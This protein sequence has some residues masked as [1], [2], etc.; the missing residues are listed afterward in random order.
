MP[1][2]GQVETR[3]RGT[4][5]SAARAR[6]GT[7]LR[8]IGPGSI[9]NPRPPMEILDEEGLK[10][11][12]DAAFQIL[13]EI[14]ID[15]M[16]E[17]AQSL[18]T[19][20]GSVRDANTGRMLIGRE[21]VTELA[22]KAP[23]QFTLHARNPDRNIILGGN[24]I[25]FSPVASAPFATD[26]D[27][28]RRTGRYED[29]CGLLKLAQTYNV[30]HCLAG[31]PVEPVD[32]PVTTRHLDA[33]WGYI[34]LTDKVWHPY[35]IGRQRIRDAVAMLALARGVEREQLIDE[36]GLITVINTNSPLRLDQ[37]LTEG[38]IEA[39]SWGQCLCITPFTL[40]GAMG[41]VTLAGAL[42]QSHA[43]ALATIAVTQLVR[44]G[45]PVIY[46]CFTSNVDMKTGAPVFGTPEYVRATLA[47][48]QL[49]RR[50]GLPYR[51]SAGTAANAPDSQST[52]EHM[53]SLTA[54]VSAHANLIK[55]SAGWLEGGLCASFEKLV[56][57]VET[58]Q[59]TAES[60]K[61]IEVDDASLA[62]DAIAEVGPGGHFF[63]SPHTMAR[64]E[65]AFHQPLISDWRNFESWEADGSPYVH[66][67]ANREWKNRLANYEPPPLDAGRREAIADYVARRRSEPFV[68]N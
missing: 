23:R 31:Y 39:A 38:L 15:M 14:G 9:V 42:A 56:M 68:E 48:G 30:L 3:R 41:P 35:G 8:Q 65:T 36:P 61:P 4:T 19:A 50:L 54:A 33:Y 21:I 32:L 49:A 55:H 59:I 22:A 13:E 29:Y 57:D 7:G 25:N 20:S 52:W 67:R 53:T 16:A 46:G 66:Q 44:P 63:G 62:L 45:T 40:A 12:E 18:L 6:S 1:R 43:E 11:I 17:E 51:S 24:Y 58:L 64:Y 5:R 2:E 60:L 37:A 26:L 10:R 28:G 47:A 27:H 34:T